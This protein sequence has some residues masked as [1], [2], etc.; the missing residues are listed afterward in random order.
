MKDIQ[1]YLYITAKIGSY[2]KGAG[3]Q[4]GLA[5]TRKK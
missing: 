4:N 3:R 2:K 5:R 1:C